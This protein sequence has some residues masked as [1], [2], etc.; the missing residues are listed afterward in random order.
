MVT[1]LHDGM[2]LVAKEYV[3]ARQDEDGVL[4]LSIFTGAASELRDALLV[5][6][7]DISSV[8]ETIHQGVEMSRAERRARMKRMRRHIM[9][10]NV[11]RWAANI[12][13]D[14]HDLRIDDLELLDRGRPGPVSVPPTAR[15][16]NKLAERARLG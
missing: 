9:E 7:Y 15:A 14:L 2:N 3:A 1:S 13:G 11:Y 6:P 4:V 10:H 12:L 8:A 16:Q 5:N